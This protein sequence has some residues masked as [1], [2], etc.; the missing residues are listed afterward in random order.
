MLDGGGRGAC[1]IDQNNSR[2]SADQRGAAI[3]ELAIRAN[4]VLTGI[5]VAIALA[6]PAA[7]W[8]N[9]SSVAGL[10]TGS[11]GALGRSVKAPSM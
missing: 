3:A 6:L 5:C 11:N 7:T 4:A 2:I 10:V 9:T 1:R 8:P